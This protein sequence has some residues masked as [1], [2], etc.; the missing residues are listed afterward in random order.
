[1]EYYSHCKVRKQK[2]VLCVCVCVCVGV[3]GKVLI[4]KK[5]KE[6]YQ[7]Q[8]RYK[9]IEKLQQRINEYNAVLLFSNR[10]IYVFNNF[11]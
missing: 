11:D 9:K 1:M 10:I 7:K 3:G 2:I 4:K 5:D 8:T 6:Q